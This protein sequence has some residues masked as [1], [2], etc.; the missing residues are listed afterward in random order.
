MKKGFIAKAIW[1]SL[2]GYRKTGLVIGIIAFLHIWFYCM[3]SDTFMCNLFPKSEVSF[4]REE[5]T[6]FSHFGYR[7]GMKFAPVAPIASTTSARESTAV[8]LG[9]A[10]PNLQVQSHKRTLGERY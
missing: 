4:S 10:N 7:D 5:K 3:N 2:D 6:I 9:F 1:I 8:E